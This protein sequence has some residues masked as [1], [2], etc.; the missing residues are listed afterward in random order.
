MSLQNI[1]NGQVLEPAVFSAS[2]GEAGG[3][4]GAAACLAST[5]ILA[6]R[7]AISCWKS[8]SAWVTLS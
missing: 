5:A 6:C 2:V 1:L 3:E 7:A 4:V 8:R